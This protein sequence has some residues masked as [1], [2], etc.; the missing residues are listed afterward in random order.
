[1]V[2]YHDVEWVERTMLL[3]RCLNITLDL[4]WMDG[5]VFSKSP[6]LQKVAAQVG[7]DAYHVSRCIA[8]IRDLRIEVYH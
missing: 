7:S 3:L 1:M 8:L 2:T 4:P 5:C 6:Y